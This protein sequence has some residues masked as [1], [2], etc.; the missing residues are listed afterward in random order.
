MLEVFEYLFGRLKAERPVMCDVKGQVYAVR[1]DG[2]I[3]EPV[4]D[5]AP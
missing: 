5:L 4:R 3:G 2:T 1:S